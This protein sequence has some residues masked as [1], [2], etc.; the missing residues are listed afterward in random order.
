MRALGVV[1]TL[2]VMALAPGEA[3][4]VT[5]VALTGTETRDEVR[6]VL[7]AGDLIITPA[8]GLAVTTDTGPRPCPVVTDPL[9][10]RPLG[11]RCKAPPDRVDLTADLRGGSDVLTVEGDGTLGSATAL[12]GPV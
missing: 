7:Q 9:V 4:A 2:G 12:G 8:I 10:N 3:A 5:T 11:Y 6:F 1:L